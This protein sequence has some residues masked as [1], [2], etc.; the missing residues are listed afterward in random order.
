MGRGQQQGT[1]RAFH[2][3]LKGLGDS[4]LLEAFRLQV[5]L[6]LCCVSVD[7]EGSVAH[8]KLHVC[9]CPCIS[10]QFWPIVSCFHGWCKSLDFIFLQ[11]SHPYNERMRS[12]CP[13]E[14]T[15][16]SVPEKPCKNW[17]LL[18]LVAKGHSVSRQRLRNNVVTPANP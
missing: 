7:A 11:I 9:V 6:T 8:L 10:G 13:S 18:L 12:F 17:V 4:A 1:G 14:S 2:I 15:F 3:A 5:A 16:G